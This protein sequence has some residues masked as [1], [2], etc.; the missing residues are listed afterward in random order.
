MVVTLENKSVEELLA[1]DFE[2]IND[3]NKFQPNIMEA[4]SL[5]P[6][7]E[8]HTLSP[9]NVHNYYS[10][11]KG[12]PTQKPY[13]HFKPRSETLKCLKE[14]PIKSKSRNIIY[15]KSKDSYVNKQQVRHNLVK[16]KVE[17]KLITEGGVERSHFRHKQLLSSSLPNHFVKDTYLGE[18]SLANNGRQ[19]DVLGFCHIQN[20]IIEA[21][22]EEGIEVE[23]VTF[24]QDFTTTL[25]KP[26][27]HCLKC[28]LDTL[29][30]TNENRELTCQT[31]SALKH[32]QRHHKLTRKDFPENWDQIMDIIKPL[33]NDCNNLLNRNRLLYLDLL[34]TVLEEDLHQHKLENTVRR[35]F[36]WI[37]L[38]PEYKMSNISS[39]VNLLLMAVQRT[40]GNCQDS[41]PLLPEELQRMQQHVVFLLQKLLALS[42]NVSR[43]KVEGAMKI[44]EDLIYPFRSLSNMMHRR[45]I[46][47]TID[48]DILRQK[49]IELWLENCCELKDPNGILP[50]ASE[51]M[52]VNKIV[53]RHFRFQP[54][55]EVEDV[56][57]ACE[58]LSLVHYLLLKS[59]LRNC[60][61]KINKGTKDDAA[62]YC[63]MQLSIDDKTWLV[64]IGDT[65]TQLCYHLKSFAELTPK[66][67][68]YLNCIEVFQDLVDG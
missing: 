63:G 44:A 55:K 42:V 47:E 27:E 61:E 53:N 45:Q 41:I 11:I 10:G 37:M 30:M 58:E 32:I 52:S 22:T 19:P 51:P 38:C 67:Q 9:K 56:S 66:T 43:S 34:T 12:S 1:I 33:A 39:V 31:Y 40:F 7:P 26:E 28:L 35:S 65:V 25:S 17:S 29:L 23:G 14:K 68:F 46:L 16:P 21:F 18:R 6:F 60:A 36:V 49:F 3:A 59:Y 64:G 8:R 24:I 20:N 62:C 2:D 5:L 4:S 57:L 54:S 50:A 15:S 48:C 13:G